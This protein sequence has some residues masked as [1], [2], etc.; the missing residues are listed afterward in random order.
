MELD[1]LKGAWAQYDKK[2]N[3]NLKFNE[4]LFKKLN[5]DKSKREMTTPLNYELFSVFINIGFILFFASS[6]FRYAG[7]TVLLISGVLT[8]LFML[9]FLFFSIHRLRLMSAIDYYNS[10]VIE[11]QKA[12]SKMK[13]KFFLYKRIEIFS[14]PFFTLAFLPI[15]A[16]AIR[17]FDI[18]AHPTR[19][20]IALVLGLVLGYTLALWI[21]KNWYEQKIKN[22]NDFINE[23][24]R[25]E[26]EE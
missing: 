20:A 15:G 25:F 6:T 23:L 13:N 19:F 11:L 17:N 12:L 3:E 21:Y 14:F 2:L 10:S 16:K 26:E 5:L 18:L 1:D 22:T 24:N 8:T 9:L 7:N 4:E